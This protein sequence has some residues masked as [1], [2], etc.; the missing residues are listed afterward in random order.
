MRF[1]SARVFFKPTA[2]AKP[3]TVSLE[4]QIIYWIVVFLK[5][6]KKACSD[7]LVNS[8]IGRLKNAELADKT[9]YNALS[10]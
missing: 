3:V 4:S 5:W 10:P 7:I 6:S 8:D 2:Y 1:A 9:S